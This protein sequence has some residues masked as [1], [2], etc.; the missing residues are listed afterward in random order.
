MRI[1]GFSSVA[2][3]FEERT[4]D[5]AG[6]VYRVHRD[7]LGYRVSC[8]GQDTTNARSILTAANTG[9]MVVVVDRLGTVQW[10]ECLLRRGAYCLDKAD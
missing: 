9:A 10:T 2:G 1:Y 6:F 8:M 7:N 3:D 5:F 4:S